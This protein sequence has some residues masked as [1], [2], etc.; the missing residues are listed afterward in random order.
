MKTDIYI[1]QS[2]LNQLELCPESLRLK[3]REPVPERY[4][5]DLSRG[6]V[7][8][9]AI[10]E[11]GRHMM[12]HGEATPINIIE[13]RLEELMEADFANVEWWKQKQDTTAKHIRANFEAW[14]WGVAPELMP[15]AIE[16]T[17]RVLLEETETRRIWLTGTPDWL[18]HDGRL[19]DWKNPKPKNMEPNKGFD[20][21]AREMQKTDLQSTVYTY[22]RSVE[23]DEWS[24]KRFDL[25]LLMNGEVGWIPIERGPADWEAL[26]DKCRALAD[27]IQAPLSV[28]PHRWTSW[29]CNPD[30]CNH[31]A[32]CRGK[33]YDGGAAW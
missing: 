13:R 17:F 1:R 21:H 31:W 10:E 33:H 25:C 19:L 20:M 27:L 30:W 12:V 26:K 3:Y 2:D 15:I 28:W 29:Y 22:A 4:N 18:N 6:N 24:P 14:Y 7:V 32:E 16:E 5:S 11:V 23:L 8:H 9:A